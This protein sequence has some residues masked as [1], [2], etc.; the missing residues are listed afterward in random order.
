M[1]NKKLLCIPRRAFV[2]PGFHFPFI[3]CSVQ[4]SGSDFWKGQIRFNWFQFE[5]NQFFLILGSYKKSTQLIQAG[6]FTWLIF[7]LFCNKNGKTSNNCDSWQFESVTIFSVKNKSCQILETTFL[8]HDF[9]LFKYK[10]YSQRFK[11]LLKHD[12]SSLLI[13]SQA[14]L[15]ALLIVADLSKNSTLEV[16][17]LKCS[18]LHTLGRLILSL[19]LIHLFFFPSFCATHVFLKKQNNNNSFG[20]VPFAR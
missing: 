2:P 14:Q 10:I 15:N 5:K 20:D 9:F 1:H 4:K 3:F 18:W 12:I 19:L 11:N 7:F 16:T 17:N 8:H 6:W 13:T